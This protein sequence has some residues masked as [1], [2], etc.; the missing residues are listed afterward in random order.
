MSRCRACKLGPAFFIL[1]CTLLR[2]Q[3]FSP[4]P[5]LSFVKPF[6][7]ADPLP[8]TV[9]ITST[10]TNF[11]FSATGVTDTGGNWLSVTVVGFNCCATP[12][13]ITAVVTTLPAMTAGTYMGHIA[14]V[15][16]PSGSITMNIPVVLTVAPAAGTFFDNLPGQ[17]SFALNTG[18][19]AIASQQIQVRNGGS[20]TL[21]WNLATSTSDAGNWLSVSATSGTAPSVITVGISVANLPGGGLV[22]GHFIGQLVF[23]QGSG[24][25]VTIPVSVV[26]GANIFSQV[27]GI[28]FTKVFG[29][30]DPLPQTLTIPSTGTNFDFDTNSYTA[31]G[32]SWLSASARGFNCCATPRAITAVVTT[33]PT[34]AVG[35]YTGQIVF[36][37][38]GNGAS[39]ITVPVTLTVEPAAGTFFNNM[40]GQLSFALI[41]G[42]AAITPQRIQVGNGGSGTLNWNLATSTADTGNWLTISAASGTAP[43]VIAVGISVANLPGGGLFAGEFIGQLLFSQGA[44]GSVTIPVSVVVGV[45]IFSQ[46]NGINFTKVYGGADPLPQ[47]LTIPSTG[48]N[49]DFDTNWY[50]ATGGSWLSVSEVGLNCCATPRAVTAIV[51]TSATLAVGTYTGQIVFTVEGNGAMAITVPVTLTVEPLTGTFFDNLP[52]QLSFAMMTGGTKITSQQIQVRN[53]G[54]GSLDWTVAAN[55]ADGG[56]WLTASAQ[57]GTAP[58]PITVGVSVASLPGGGLIAGHFIGQLVLSQP[59]G[60]SV[61]I[62]V[63]VVVGANIFNQV[64]GINFTKVAA[65]A[66]PLPQTLT[67]SSTGTN[68]DFET[69]W[70]TATGGTWLSVKVVGFNCCATPRAITAV[71]TTSPTLAA[72]TY[73]GQIVFTPDSGSMAITVPVTLTVEPA[74]ATFFDD[75]PGQ[76]SFSFVPASGNPPMQNLQIRQRGSGTLNW[77]LAATTADSGNWLTASA[78]SGTGPAAV[79]VG[80]VTAAL[81]GGGLI[82]GTFVGDL[83]LSSASGITTIP[84]SVTV[85]ANVFVQLPSLSF[86][87]TFGTANPPSQNLTIAST[88][89][90]FDFDHNWY[91]AT[92]GN[93]LTVTVAGFNCCATPRAITANIVASPTLAAGTYTGQ[94]V[95][96]L[97]GNGSMAM[98]VPVILTVLPSP[99]IASLTPNTG[100]AGQTLATVAVAGQN[101]AFAQGTTVASFGAGIT[102][103]SLTVNSPTSATANITIQNAAV[104]G[105]RTVTLTTGTEVAAL[106]GGFTVIA[107]AC[108][109][110]K[111]GSTTVVDVQLIINEALGISRAVNDLNQDSTVSVVDV[112]IVINAVLLLGCPF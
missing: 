80:V 94:I 87:K 53:G 9:T 62:P 47:T 33:S 38:E 69:R 48:T 2:A 110:N 73:T 1:F 12:R 68:F 14:L 100:L 72:G 32:G 107:S 35:T 112:Q 75:V 28:N 23:S 10:G 40:P 21:N 101:T 8:Q 109:L 22:A 6:A 44:G 111:D 46:V 20:G 29:G 93:W 71:V 58:S 96:T 36:T 25:S 61:T 108:D 18:G 102:V 52:G 55:T 59:S 83:V 67:I 91:T 26:V 34:M 97:E 90:N 41:T 76:M 24:G 82:A 104:P 16:S 51:T 103:N 45:N 77:A 99:A 15:S 39:A 89:T 4:V 56:A 19:A 17:L 84:V 74:A 43:S 78:S 66:D 98:T 79:Q 70:Y 86:T 27:N 60:G 54:Q 85:G 30:A 50:T 81:P 64:N 57:S 7:G 49:F 106:T 11:D 92:G 3:T 105:T 5:T 31:T 13:A 37:V 65:G 88:G 63:S 95:T 42:G